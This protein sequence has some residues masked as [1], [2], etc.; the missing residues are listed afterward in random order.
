MI[1]ILAMLR[2]TF[3]QPIEMK[4]LINQKTFMKF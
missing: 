1:S 4:I 3:Q 2:E